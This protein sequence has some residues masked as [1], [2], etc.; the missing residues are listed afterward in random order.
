MPNPIIKI[1]DLETN[2]EIERPMTNEEFALWQQR[3][4]E[5]AQS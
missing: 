3:N 4:E 2:Q 1:H 5:F